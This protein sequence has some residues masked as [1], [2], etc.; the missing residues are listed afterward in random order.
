VEMGAVPWPQ[1]LSRRDDASG[2][3]RVAALEKDTVQIFQRDFGGR[4]VRLGN[5]CVLTEA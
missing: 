5:W 1:P 3:M 4:L 2:W